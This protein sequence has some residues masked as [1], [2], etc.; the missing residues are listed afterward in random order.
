MFSNWRY[1]VIFRDG[2]QI[3][4]RTIRYMYYSRTL[5]AK[6]SKNHEENNLIMDNPFQNK[7]QI[8]RWIKMNNM[9]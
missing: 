2:V 1:D 9:D 8:K 6:Q 7:E 3:P 4:A 5:T